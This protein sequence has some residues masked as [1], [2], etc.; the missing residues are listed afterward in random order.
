M[1]TLSR[2]QT[3][4]LPDFC[5]VRMAITVIL[6]GELLAIVL[7]LANGGLH[8]SRFQT[9]AL[10]SLFIQWVAL[11]C[12]AILCL[13]RSR[14]NRLAD[15]WSTLL[16]YLTILVVTVIVTE[17][18]WW[19]LHAMPA[20]SLGLSMDAN[21]AQLLVRSVGISSI[22]S[23]LALRYFYVQH[24]WRRHVQAEAEARLQALQ[25]RIRPHFLFNCMNTIASLTR[26]EPALAEQAIEDLADLF[27]LSLQETRSW[28]TLTEEF[29]ICRRYLR[30]E[31]LRLGE[32]LQVDWQAEALPADA[33]VPA[34]LIQPL[35]ENA[36]YHGIEPLAAGGRIDILGE[37]DG[38]RLTV[39][40]ENPLAPGVTLHNHGNR[41]AQDNIRQRLESV[42][43]GRAVLEIDHAD[44]RYR[45]RLTFPYER[46]PCASS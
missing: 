45:V 9:L 25:A 18:A 8:Q 10:H 7:T 1:T 23:A 40:I 15:I 28:L 39:T 46:E 26:R 3:A 27:R 31:Q 34:L 33:C 19:L 4:Y 37:R 12:V 38:D 29:D 21:H 2:Q 24:Q 22:V 41:L 20:G 16:S 35:L 14:L 42:F 11:S 32:R 30:T 6:T 5:G 43:G 36:V 44:D 17:V 13:L